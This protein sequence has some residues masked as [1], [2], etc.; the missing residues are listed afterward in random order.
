MHVVKAC[1]YRR[2]CYTSI[3]LDRDIHGG[4]VLVYVRDDI[5]YRE[6]KTRDLE[7]VTLEI[8]L[9]KSKWLLFGGYNHTKS[10]MDSFLN[11][12]API[13][14]THMGRLENFI[15]L[16]DFNSEVEEAVMK[17]FCETYNLN[18]LVF[19]PTCFKNPIN[20]SSIDLVLTNKRKKL[21]KYHCC[22]N[23]IVRPP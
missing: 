2:P 15:I 19:G 20:P 8:N 11:L 21:P 4:G 12:L 6:D 14:D 13:I 5:P 18:N 9:R 7:E 3:R 22:G 17:S 1:I 16:G 10:N 23:M